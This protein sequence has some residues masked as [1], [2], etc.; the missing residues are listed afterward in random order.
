M[1]KAKKDLI[2]LKDKIYLKQK[3]LMEVMYTDKIKYDDN[4]IKKNINEIFLLEFIYDSKKDLYDYD[5]KM[6]WNQK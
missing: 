3:N 4:R 1:L 5:Y 6:F 2:N